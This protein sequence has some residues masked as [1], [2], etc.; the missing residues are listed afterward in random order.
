MHWT[1]L[2]WVPMHQKVVRR[3]SVSDL[4]ASSGPI[5]LFPA[6]TTPLPPRPGVWLSTSPMPETVKRVDA[7]GIVTETVP[8]DQLQLIGF[9]V[10]VPASLAQQ[11]ADPD[12]LL[13][14]A[15]ASGIAQALPALSAQPAA[16][17]PASRRPGQD[18]RGR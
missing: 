12:D 3:V 2:E 11:A 4:L 1:D 13:R 17:Q 16:G 10:V 18:P 8:R 15:L 14:L 7:D 5:T 9:P 6:G